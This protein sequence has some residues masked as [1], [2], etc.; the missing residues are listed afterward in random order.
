MSPASHLLS[1]ARA[2][3]LRIAT[4][5]PLR[6]GY[7]AVLALIATWPLLSNASALNEFRDA[8]VLAHYE[9]AARLAVVRF[10]EVPLW[11]PYYCGGMYLLGTP[12]ARFVSP[13]FLLTLLFGEGR[14]EALS[15]FAMLIVGLEGT[16]RYARSRGASARGAFLAAP[17]FGLSGVFAVAPQLGWI[18]F[19]GFALLPWIAL[20]LRR[21]FRGDVRGALIAAGCIAWCAG[22]G[23]TY[24]VPMAALWCVLE[25]I[26]A[27][28]HRG[29]PGAARVLVMGLLVASLGAGLGAVRLWPVAETLADAPRVVGGTPGSNYP[30][31]G[32]MLFQMLA[33]ESIDGQFFIGLLVVPAALL[34]LSRV[35]GLALAAYAALWVWLAAGYGVVPSLFAAT[36]ALPVYGTLRYPERYLI[37]LALVASVLCA[38]G[39]TVSLARS[40]S[41]RRR[42]WVWQTLYLTATFTLAGAVVPLLMQH[43]K[44]ADMRELAAPPIT[45]DGPF[46]QSR[47]N[48]WE[49]AYY[50][51]IQRGSL[52]CWDAY[53]VPESP[54][55]T[56]DRAVEEW[57]DSPRVG[58]VTERF[59]S[60][61]RIDLD[62]DLTEP[63]RLRVNQNWH[64]GWRTSRGEVRSDRGLLVV[65]LPAGKQAVSLTFS[66]RSAS[67]GL[68]VSIVSL[69]GVLILM[70]RRGSG[71]LTKLGIALLPVAAL[72]VAL[73]TI[74][75]PAPP[76]KELL[77]PTGEPIVA[78]TLGEGVIRIDA[79]FEGGMT[80]AAAAV[81]NP[82]PHPGDTIVLELDWI[83]EPKVDPG[84]GVFVHIDPSSGDPLNGDHVELSQTLLIDAAPAGKILRDLLPITLPTDSAKKEWT[85]TV[86]LW[87]IQRGG[88]RVPITEPGNATVEDDQI[89]VA[90]FEVN[91]IERGR[92]VDR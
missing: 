78:D 83:R 56:G 20:G 42:P 34:G 18:N 19:Y 84:L 67:G 15:A 57:F 27:L 79:H 92:S 59:W 86:G 35:R 41:A 51:A 89:T 32:R 54:L 13:T 43:Y 29:R 28:V 39:V 77:A 80:L 22:F 71:L 6:L 74:H 76:A 5:A 26:E 65:D 52:S 55:L 60:P 9:I 17:V 8:H 23:G 4:I 12:Q 38:R 3:L 1:R 30:A 40:R 68:L 25:V 2:L 7:F 64:R 14:S 46:H 45:I 53:P 31:L 61:N 16:F 72:G 75:E 63:A 87:R 48:R 69:V 88:K 33:R 44:S 49:L 66:P 24:A 81:D 37:L 82:E 36:H 10:H 85:I 11:D 50:T 90:R 62:V 91:A 47:G 58:Q 21:S 70:W 73:A